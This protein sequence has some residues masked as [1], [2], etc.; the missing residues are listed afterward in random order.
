MRILVTGGNGKIGKFV[1]AELQENGHEVRIFDLKES[2][3]TDAD[4]VKGSVT[5]PDEI[6][7]AMEGMD[8]VIHLAAIPSMLPEVPP[9]E[10][11]NVNVTGTFNVL[12]AA[13]KNNVGK[14]AIASSDSALGFV[15]S[16]NRFSPNYFPINEDHPLRPQ[17]PYGLSKLIGEELC[18]RATRRY[19]I[20]TVCLRFCWVWFPSTYAHRSDILGQTALNPKRMW[21]YVDVRDT[22]QACRLSMDSNN[23]VHD[24]LF[25]TAED[26]FA[27]ESSLDLISENYPEVRQISNDYLIEAH[28]ALF[29][30][31]KA[32]KLLGYRP[33][34]AWRNVVA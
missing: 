31:S 15:F 25:I 33:Q 30:T 16:T 24:A 13:A 21:G 23:V 3:D 10:Y 8:G 6:E 2:H 29:D 7:H 20:R 34:Y 22:A 17:D 14:V 28:K 12:E 5:R 1:V 32:K 27:D 26:T 19:G 18:G 11:M 4:F 9:A